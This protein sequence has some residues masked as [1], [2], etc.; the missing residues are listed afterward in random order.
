MINKN[1]G[2]DIQMLGKRVTLC[3]KKFVLVGSHLGE[4][5]ITDATHV[6]A[7]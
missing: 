1:F 6:G 2:I 4:R 5:G 3:N 7:V